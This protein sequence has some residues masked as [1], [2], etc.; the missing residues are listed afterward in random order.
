LIGDID[1]LI[2]ATA[3]EKG[4]TLITTDGDFSRVPQLSLRV[5]PRL[6]LRT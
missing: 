3:I 4:L 6:Q 5:V 2:A 1:T